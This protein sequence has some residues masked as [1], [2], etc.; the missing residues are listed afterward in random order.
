VTRPGPGGP[1]EQRQ[2]GRGAAAQQREQAI[3]DYLTACNAGDAEAVTAT[4]A[5][6]AMHYFPVRMYG[7]DE[8]VRG[9][10]AIGKKWA[11]PVRSP[12]SRW[13]IDGPILCDPGHHQAA[14]EFTAEQKKS[15]TIIRGS[16]WYRFDP[17]TGLIAEIRAYLASPPRKASSGWSW[18]ASRTPSAGTPPAPDI[19][20]SGSGRSTGWSGVRWR[21]GTAVPHHDVRPGRRRL[22]RQTA[23]CP[24]PAEV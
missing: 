15:A 12:G 22:C 13:S 23:H 17:G 21:E 20:G 24:R 11:R 10:R 2:S 5:P 6:D 19:P 7:D 9:G 3:G 8:P 16:K 1:Y 18:A 14:I 4:C